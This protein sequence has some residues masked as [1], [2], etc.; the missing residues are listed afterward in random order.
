MGKKVNS[1]AD[2]ES[3]LQKEMYSAMEE[4]IDKSFRNLHENLD[5]FYASPEGQYKRTGQLAESPEQE[6]SG[7]DNLVTGKLN[8][9]TSYVYRPSG[10]DTNT[11]YGYAE[12]NELLGNGGFWRETLYEIEENMNEAFGKRFH[13]K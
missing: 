1:W 2:L 11:I 10:R 5:Y 9:D 7:G 12:D 6:I 8:L 3:A 13:K 4:T